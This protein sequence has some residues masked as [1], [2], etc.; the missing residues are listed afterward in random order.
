M[1]TST[2]TASCAAGNWLVQRAS[3]ADYVNAKLGYFELK[4]PTADALCTTCF[5]I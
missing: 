4:G 5:L 1:T 2:G 3:G